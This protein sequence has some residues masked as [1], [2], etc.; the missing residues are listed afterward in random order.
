[1]LWLWRALRALPGVIGG[2]SGVVV[3]VVKVEPRSGIGNVSKIPEHC[4]GANSSLAQLHE[5]IAVRIPATFTPVQVLRKG[6]RAESTLGLFWCSHCP[7]LH[8]L[9]LTLHILLVELLTTVFLQ[10]CFRCLF[11]LLIVRPAC[12]L[13][14]F[15]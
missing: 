1:M 9:L 12:C 15:A 8:E 7:P 2:G 10:P 3:V 13:S 4:F 14:L 5:V 11:P 6:K